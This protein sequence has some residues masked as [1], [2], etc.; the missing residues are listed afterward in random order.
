[1]G[2]VF[3]N[4]RYP[5][6]DVDSGGNVNG[7]I[8]AAGRVLALAAS[9]TKIIPGHG[10]L[11]DP[12][13]LRVYRDMLVVVRDKVQTMIND[14]KGVDEVVASKPTT[15]FDGEWEGRAERFVRGV[16]YSLQKRPDT[17]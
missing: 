8:D 2:D 14:G 5:F 10:P 17:Y 12:D 15:P 9:D 3:F 4:G 16:Y 13:D 11:A 7:I 6:I 1:M